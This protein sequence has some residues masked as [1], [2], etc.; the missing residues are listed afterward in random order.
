MHWAFK[1]MTKFQKQILMH[2]SVQLTFLI[3]MHWPGHVMTMFFGPVLKSGDNLTLNFNTS[4][5]VDS[6]T[7]LLRIGS[8]DHSLSPTTSDH[9]RGL[10]TIRFLM[11]IME[12]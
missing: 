5:P 6:P 4:E 8:A 1:S 10:Q 9:S 2:R 3:Q 12:R 11:Q 7:I